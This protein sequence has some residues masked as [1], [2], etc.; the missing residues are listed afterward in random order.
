MPLGNNASGRTRA[1]LRR[2]VYL[3]VFLV[4]VERVLLILACFKNPVPWSKV[5]LVY[6]LSK[7][8]GHFAVTY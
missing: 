2:P 7:C 5:V 3:L 4:G 6:H 1:R 8:K